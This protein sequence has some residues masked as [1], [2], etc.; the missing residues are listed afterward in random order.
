[1]GIKNENKTNAD[2]S[3]NNNTFQNS[4]S[5]VEKAK[6]AKWREIILKTLGEAEKKSIP[7]K[8]TKFS[9]RK[10]KLSASDSL[11]KFVVQPVVKISDVLSTQKIE[12]EKKKIAKKKETGN[13]SFQSVKLTA[14]KPSKYLSIKISK[15]SV[16]DSAIQ[17]PEFVKIKKPSLFKRSVK[18]F[19]I[20]LLY[21][22]FLS[23]V[24]VVFFGIGL[25][26]YQWN[27]K[28]TNQ[29]IKIVPYPVAM[30]NGSILSYGEFRDDVS[31]LARYYKKRE[32]AS[33]GVKMAPSP[34]KNKEDVLR[35]MIINELIKQLASKHRID[36]SQQ[37][38]DKKFQ[39]ISI[40]APG[41]LKVS[42]IIKNLYGW[43]I[44]TYKERIL[45]PSLLSE[46]LN[47]YFLTSQTKHLNEVLKE[48]QLQS[49]IRRFFY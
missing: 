14:K 23:L 19:S 6:V 36:L 3:E 40:N 28:L 10:G 45:R 7:I 26:K 21:F 47:S 20:L 27:D 24:A 30:I 25:Y 43:N 44:E 9:K 13:G 46:K 38:L 11:K 29:I 1:M 34:E 48:F 41:Q 37:E 8:K 2:S 33:R 35:M 31:A 5:S 49:E 15:K 12:S 42:E 18:F 16:K 32:E 17:P 4:D 39:E 22:V